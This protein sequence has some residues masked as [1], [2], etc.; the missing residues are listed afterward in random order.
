MRPPYSR[1]A[2]VRQ[3]VVGIVAHTPREWLHGHGL[4]ITEIYEVIDAR[5]DAEIDEA[6]R[7][8]LHDQIRPQDD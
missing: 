8:A 6:V 3:D 1:A 7:D 5:T 2:R 4:P